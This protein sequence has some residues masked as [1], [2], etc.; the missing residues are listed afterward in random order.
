MVVYASGGERH[1]LE[2]T[3]YSERSA[4]TRPNRSAPRRSSA[5]R[6]AWLAVRRQPSGG[7]MAILTIHQFDPD[8]C[9]A[10]SDM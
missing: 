5:T 4:H 1:A 10:V 9:V 3:R 7:G 2:A 6:T 8:G